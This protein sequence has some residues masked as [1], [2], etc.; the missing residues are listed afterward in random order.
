MHVHILT[1]VKAHKHQFKVQIV[2]CAHIHIY[3]AM[4]C[5]NQYQYTLMCEGHS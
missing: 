5:L 3:I 4:C 1:Q 2:M